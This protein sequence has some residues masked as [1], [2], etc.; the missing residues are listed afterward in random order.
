M[1]KG[2]S[3]LYVV[4][5]LLIFTGIGASGYILIKQ[6]TTTITEETTTSS[7]TTTT[8]SETTSTTTLPESTTT[9]PTTTITIQTCS[10]G[11]PYGE[12]SSTKPK[13]CD[14]GNLIDKCSSCG[15]SSGQ[16]CEN[17]GSCC[18][19]SCSEFGLKGCSDNYYQICG[20]Y[21]ND[22]CLEWGVITPCSIGES[23]V[24]GNCI[25]INSPDPE[26]E[27]RAVFIDTISPTSSI[28]LKNKVI[29][30]GW[31]E[32][33]IK[34]LTGESATYTNF[35]D[36]LDWLANNSDSNDIVLIS[37][38]SHG[39][40]IGLSLLE[41][42]LTYSNFAEK[43]DEINYDG[44]GIMIS[45]CAYDN[46]ITYLKK[47]NRV[48]LLAGDFPGKIVRVLEGFGDIDYNNDNWV[49]LEEVYEYQRTEHTL[50]L[51]DDYVGDL[52]LVFLDSNLRYLDQYNIK[53]FV[54]TGLPAG[55]S[56][57]NDNV[58]LAQSFKPNYPILTKIMLDL[59]RK[60]DGVGPLIVS[61]RKNLTDD[62]LTIVSV[63]QESFPYTETLLGKIYEIDFPDVEITPGETYYIVIRAPSATWQGVSYKSVYSIS[64]SSDVYYS[65]EV[66]TSY[67]SGESW[68]ALEDDPIYSSAVPEADLVFATFGKT[69]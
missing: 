62:D 34:C 49:S 56:L 38:N 60:S 33:H 25:A 40:S 41:E 22:N 58:W 65:G 23:C 45:A 4:L 39:S 7:S 12:C 21:D 54:A 69:K 30:K 46:A 50:P 18:K 17:D 27:Y 13:Y 42:F 3:S 55:E 8:I 14:N 35:M 36:A 67:N 68:I 44:L 61:I 63:P 32:D 28:L 20:N 1:S 47:E 29:E 15:C 5:L 16:E 51:E 37:T 10:D 24:R 59:D 19:N 31:Q 53:S 2:I 52:N 57:E 64:Y 66:F 9:E 26:V 6:S 48:I 43:L 11:T